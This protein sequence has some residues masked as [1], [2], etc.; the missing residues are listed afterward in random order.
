MLLD[1]GL[2]SDVRRCR[3]STRT[4]RSAV[5]TPVY[6]SPEQAEDHALGPA[7]DW[8]SVGVMLYEA[9]T[10]R[11]PFEGQPL[12]RARAQADR[13]SRR[14]RASSRLTC[15]ATSTRCAC[16]LLARNPAQRP[17]GKAILAALGRAPSAATLQ[18]AANTAPRFVGRRSASSMRSRA[19]SATRA[20]A[21]GRRRSSAAAR[22]WARARSSDSSSTR[23]RFP[24][25]RSC[26][27]AAA[28]SASPCR[29]RG[30]TA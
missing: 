15:R 6:M 28:T 1:F 12:Q 18:L 23:L 22:G 11:R 27:R 24:R 29:T 5:G 26:S 8:Y 14:R 13:G 17:D 16:E 10:G 4:R 2:T 20:R 19:H 30:S 21:A 9:L 3:R 7:S 25:A